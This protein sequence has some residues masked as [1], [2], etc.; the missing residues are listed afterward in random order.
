MGSVRLGA[1]CALVLSLATPEARA[2]GGC[3]H[4]SRVTPSQP[5]ALDTASV[6]TDHRMVLALSTTETTLWDQIA[7]AGRPQDFVWALPLS[8]VRSARV[9]VSDDGFVNTLDQATAPVVTATVP[10]RCVRDP[11][12]GRLSQVPASRSEEVR[13]AVRPVVRSA[14]PD[15]PEDAGPAVIAEETVGPYQTLLLDGV[16]EG[17]HLTEWLTAN[18]YAVPEGGRRAVAHYTELGSGWIVLRLR[19]NEGVTRMRPVRVTLDGYQPAL[20]LRMIA[21]G[22]GDAMGVA[23]MVV[24]NGP[25]RVRGLDERRV[26]PAR[27]TW[28]ANAS[29]SNYDLAFTEALGD[30]TGAAWITESIKLGFGV[31][32]ATDD[33]RFVAAAGGAVTRLRTLASAALLERDLVLEPSDATPFAGVFNARVVGT[34][35]CPSAGDAGTDAA[36]ELPRYEATGCQCATAPNAQPRGALAMLGFAVILVAKRRRRVGVNEPLD[37]RG[38]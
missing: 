33:E 23:L 19:P 8:N 15:R 4:A 34:L 35:T 26:D 9:A 30:R 37:A 12:T 14:D 11:L 5:T 16:S 27:I 22:A 6:V 13:L 29:R 31:A 28:S 32:P 3:F 38:R 1:L 20:P 7:W 18:G 21:S 10:V 2:C 24:S 25:M 17:Q 36:V